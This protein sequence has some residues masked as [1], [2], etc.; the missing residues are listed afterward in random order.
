MIG[1]AIISIVVVC[2]AALV[3]LFLPP[4]TN[5]ITSEQEAKASCEIALKSHLHDFKKENEKWE[6]AIVQFDPSVDRWVCTLTGADARKLFIIMK[7]KTGGF[8]V[9]G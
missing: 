3:Y 9:T 4:T 5:V 1:L 2:A 8:E 7:P 6:I